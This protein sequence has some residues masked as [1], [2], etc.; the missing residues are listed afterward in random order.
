MTL[1]NRDET[2][3]DSPATMK[4]QKPIKASDS[5][6]SVVTVQDEQIKFSNR[7]LKLISFH[8]LEQAKERFNSGGGRRR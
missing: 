5:T 7:I 8:M 1:T 3:S 6:L 2:D 4:L